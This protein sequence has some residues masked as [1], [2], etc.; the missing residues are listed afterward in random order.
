MLETLRN[1]ILM[2]DRGH[3]CR[4]FAVK[5]VDG[6]FEAMVRRAVARQARGGAQ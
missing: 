2:H 3:V 6:I 5:M 1:L 4:S